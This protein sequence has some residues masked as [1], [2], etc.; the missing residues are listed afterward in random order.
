MLPTCPLAGRSGATLRDDHFGDPGAVPL[1]KH[2]CALS[3]AL[4]REML[5]LLSLLLSLSIL[6]ASE[7]SS[8]VFGCCIRKNLYPAPRRA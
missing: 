5:L 3:P 7:P 2:V 8:E 4:S 1:T 6:V